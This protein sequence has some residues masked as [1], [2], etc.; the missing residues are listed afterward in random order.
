M[1]WRQNGWNGMFYPIFKFHLNKDGHLINISDRINPVG[2]I[3]YLIFFAVFS[4][5]WLYWVFDDFYPLDYWP[6]IVGWF[7]FSGIFLLISF[8]IYRMEKQFQLAQI[9]EIL[10]ID[11]KSKKPEKEWG[12]KSMILRIITYSI[13]ISLLI[14]CF[15]F[16]I[17]SGG[18]LSA[19]GIL[20]IVGVYLYTDLKIL[21]KKRKNYRQHG[22]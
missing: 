22:V 18:Y 5:P 21:L 17:P 10:E 15:V 9:Y 7:I 1:V 20:S 6:Q 13:S 8:K 4:L 19:F 12:F 2:P 11:L 3:I 14:V 16:V